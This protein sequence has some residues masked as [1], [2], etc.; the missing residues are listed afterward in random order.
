[1]DFYIYFSIVVLITVSTVSLLLFAIGVL[2]ELLNP[3]PRLCN[4]DWGFDAIDFVK[5]RELFEIGE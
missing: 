5:T 1:M 2:F 3:R 4:S